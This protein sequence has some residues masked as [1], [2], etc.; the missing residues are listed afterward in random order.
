MPAGAV[1]GVEAVVAAG[2]AAGAAGA[3][4]GL[5]AG[6][7]G[8]AV[9]AGGAVVGAA[10]GL[11]CVADDPQA[12]TSTGTTDRSARMGKLILMSNRTRAYPATLRKYPTG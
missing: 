8:G 11:I 9:A 12:L 7:G 3:V 5:A 2:C 4:V 1:V 6:V 10:V